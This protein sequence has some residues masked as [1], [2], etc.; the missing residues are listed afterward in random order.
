MIVRKAIA[1]L[2]YA[3]FVALAT[4]LSAQEQAKPLPYR[5][6]I[7]EGYV[8][9]IRVDFDAEG[10]PALPIEEGFYVFKF[11]ESGHLRTSSHDV[12]ESRRNQ[13]F[14]YSSEGKYRIHVGGPLEQRLVQEEFSGPGLGHRD[15]VPNHYRYFFIGPKDVFDDYQA[16]DVKQQPRE[17]DG[18]PKVGARKWLTRDDLNRMKIQAD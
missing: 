15:P 5:F 7:P 3:A 17:A 16:L 13:F 9:W 14:Y 6:L 10:A 4:T 2:R 1:I 12:V 11:P 18:Y 8:G